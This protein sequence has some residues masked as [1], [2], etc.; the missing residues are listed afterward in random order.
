MGKI[1]HQ[2]ISG[3]TECVHFIG[4]EAIYFTSVISVNET[5]KRCNIDK[6]ILGKHLFVSLSNKQLKINF[7]LDDRC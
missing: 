5:S 3:S 6:I 4:S 2:P 7:T 1:Q